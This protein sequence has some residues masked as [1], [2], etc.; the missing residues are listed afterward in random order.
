ME[1]TLPD[2]LFTADEVGK[3]K[4]LFR[5]GNDDEYAAALTRVTCAALTEYR[6]M[7]LG[8][9]LPSRADE[10]RQ[11]RLFHLIK[12]YFG[13]RLPS[14]A[15]VSAMFQLPQSQSR[16]L[17]RYVITRFHYALEAEVRATL[18]DTVRAAKKSK[19]DYRVVIQSDNVVD[20]LNRIIAVT[21]PELDPITKIRNTA[22]TYFISADSY[23]ALK[24]ALGVS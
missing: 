19:N 23:D 7:F 14:E 1:I 8:I 10:I 17:I 12:H 22:R 24:K 3:L 21:A 5:A 20:E 15:E 18:G 9:G 16:N 11:H 4:I 6:D 2:E 13:Q